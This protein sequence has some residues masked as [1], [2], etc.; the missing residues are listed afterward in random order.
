MKRQD[1]PISPDK[2]S[3][4]KLYDQT[5]LKFKKRSLNTR[6]KIRFILV[7]WLTVCE[8]WTT[9]RVMEWKYYSWQWEKGLLKSKRKIKQ[10][11]TVVL[12]ADKLGCYFVCLQV[13][14]NLT[15]FAWVRCPLQDMHSRQFEAASV[16]SNLVWLYWLHKT[17]DSYKYY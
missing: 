17:F 6:I 16:H 13:C 2:L 10:E 15:G 3:H 14:W 8:L 4:T 1:P 9:S 12:L 11:G 7:R 5:L